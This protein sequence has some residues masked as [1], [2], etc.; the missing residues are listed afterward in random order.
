[1]LTVK[2]QRSLARLNFRDLSALAVLADHAE[3]MGDPTAP[4]LHCAY[5]RLAALSGAPE[6]VLAALE[7]WRTVRQCWHDDVMSKA[8]RNAS[9]SSRLLHMAHLDDCFSTP[10]L[11]IRLGVL[12]PKDKTWLLALNRAEETGYTLAGIGAE[13]WAPR[14]E[15][16]VTGYDANPRG[17]PLVILEGALPETGKVYLSARRFGLILRVCPYVS[18]FTNAHSGGPVL[19]MADRAAHN[20]H[21]WCA[22]LMTISR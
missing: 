22:V 2:M 10:N 18:I 11:L 9:R 14:D 20:A 15:L 13:R 3:E 4:S 1:M 8:S 17:E 16:R 19:F 5:D 7:K 6:N 12:A 21:E